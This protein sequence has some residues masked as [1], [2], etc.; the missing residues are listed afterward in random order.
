MSWCSAKDED[1]NKKYG[2]IQL[3]PGEHLIDFIKGPESGL[4]STGLKVRGFHF[5]IDPGHTGIYPLFHIKGTYRFVMQVSSLEGGEPTRLVLLV[6][7][8][9]KEFA[10]RSEHNEI[11][12]AFRK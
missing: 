8:N 11:L 1:S 6:D 4:T 3:P 10:V 5:K 2:A 12:E 7:W 9:G